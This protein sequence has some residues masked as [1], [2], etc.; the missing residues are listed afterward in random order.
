LPVESNAQFCGWKMLE[1]LTTSYWIV[2]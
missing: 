2:C 1:V